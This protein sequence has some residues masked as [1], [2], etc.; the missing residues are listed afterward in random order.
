MEEDKAINY[1]DGNSYWLPS[2]KNNLLLLFKEYPSWTNVTRPHYPFKPDPVASSTGS[3]L[4]FK[5]L[6][7]DYKL[8]SLSIQRFLIQHL[9]LLNGATKNGRRNLLLLKKKEKSTRTREKRS[10]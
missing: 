2:I 1:S 8:V 6:M 4:Y 10:I 7:V 3:E 9:K 5:I